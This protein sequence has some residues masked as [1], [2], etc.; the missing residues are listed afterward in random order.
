MQPWNSDLT[1]PTH[2]LVKK[3]VYTACI[4]DFSPKLEAAKFT[5][6]YTLLHLKKG[7]KDNYI[8]KMK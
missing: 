3:H 1:Q 8:F 6:V 4:D 7:I 2:L 5:K